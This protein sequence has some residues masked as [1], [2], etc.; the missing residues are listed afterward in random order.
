MMDGY[1][2]PKADVSQAGQLSKSLQIFLEFLLSEEIDPGVPE[3]LRAQ[4]VN[5]LSNLRKQTKRDLQV[6][7]CYLYQDP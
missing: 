5:T 7:C 1:A 3:L 4:G 6:R 2:D